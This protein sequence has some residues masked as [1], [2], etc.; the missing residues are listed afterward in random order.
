MVGKTNYCT[1]NEF[2]L[3]RMKSNLLVIIMPLVA[4][5]LIVSCGQNSS[6]KTELE[7]IEWE[8]SLQEREMAL[9]EKDLA[10]Q[11]QKE[12]EMPELQAEQTANHSNANIGVSAV[13][14]EKKCNSDIQVAGTLV[15][16]INYGMPC[17]YP[18][19]NIL[20]DDGRTLKL[21]LDGE[22]QNFKIDNH[23]F[24]KW[25]NDL[26]YNFLDTDFSDT[27]QFPNDAFDPA[28]LN[29]EYLFC[30]Y[31]MQLNCF[32]DPNAPKEYFCKRI[33]TK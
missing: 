9:K 24:F 2:N 20:S 33:L 3:Y 8:L 13:V 5:I 1:L 16:V 26:I 6:N 11:F 7:L 21:F 14:D 29:K 4:S 28:V 22:F 32:D 10:L 25:S 17:A 15:G 12:D 23:K 30:C 19:L 18:Y 27:G 31:K